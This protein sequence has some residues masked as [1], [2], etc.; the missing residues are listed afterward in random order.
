MPLTSEQI[1]YQKKKFHR[2]MLEKELVLP[3]LVSGQNGGDYI[4]EDVQEKFEIWLSAI[5]SV[6]IE[7]PMFQL[8]DDA[9]GQGRGEYVMRELLEI[10]L[11]KQGYKVKP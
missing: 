2:A 10:K 4:D 6:E 7:L 9:D 8:M 1:E 3:Y 11:E 5:E